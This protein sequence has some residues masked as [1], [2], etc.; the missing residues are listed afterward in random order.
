MPIKTM[1]NNINSLEE[2]KNTASFNNQDALFDLIQSIQTKMNNENQN[3][4]QDNENETKAKEEIKTE[5]VP[6]IN[7]TIDTEPIVTQDTQN[8][9]LNDNNAIGSLLQNLDMSKLS[10]ILSAFSGNKETTQNTSTKTETADGGFNLGDIDPNMIL[11]FQRIISTM[12]KPDEKKNLLISLK[13][14][15]RKS[16][17][18]KLSEYITIL[19]IINA[20]DLFKGKGSD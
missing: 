11:K 20:F 4:S 8:N 3:F 2:T 12:T 13:P 15:L 9:T 6:N 10:G 19:T 1:E 5:E 14:F 7:Q 16:R 18:D 17:Q